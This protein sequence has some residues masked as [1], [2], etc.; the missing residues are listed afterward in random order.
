MTR[1]QTRERRAEED[2]DGSRRHRRQL[3]E[4]SFEDRHDRRP[5]RIDIGAAYGHVTPQPTIH[6]R[7]T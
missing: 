7:V 4:V 5:D 3:V 6:R 1:R 2:A